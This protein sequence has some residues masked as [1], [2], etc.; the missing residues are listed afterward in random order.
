MLICIFSTAFKIR[1]KIIIRNLGHCIFLM[2][3]I[4]KKQS[5]TKLF[6]RKISYDRGEYYQHTK[7]SHVCQL[8]VYHYI[9]VNIYIKKKPRTKEMVCQPVS[10]LHFPALPAPPCPERGLTPQRAFA[11]LPD[12]LANGTCWWEN[13]QWEE[14]QNLSYSPLSFSALHS[15]SN[16]REVSSLAPR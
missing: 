11:Q 6:F 7:D 9:F 1:N 10:L 5:I 16:S 2:Q 4:E 15:I 14:R 3:C 8:S 12:G 13:G